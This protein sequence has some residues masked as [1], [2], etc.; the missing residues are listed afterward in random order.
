[1]GLGVWLVDLEARN[2]VLGRR[3]RGVVGV[4]AGAAVGAAEA[5]LVEYRAGRCAGVPWRAGAGAGGLEGLAAL[6]GWAGA[7]RIRGSSH[8]ADGEGQPPGERG[9]GGQG[10]DTYD[11]RLHV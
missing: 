8:A 4:S 11:E 3:A 1:M 2:V 6:V 9:G 5:G 7:G 10:A